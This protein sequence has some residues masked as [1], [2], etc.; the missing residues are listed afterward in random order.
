MV[1]YLSDAS[2]LA[3]LLRSVSE[4]WVGVPLWH[5]GKTSDLEPKASMETDTCFSYNKVLSHFTYMGSFCYLFP[6]CSAQFASEASGWKAKISSSP[7]VGLIA[8]W[9]K[10]NFFALRKFGLSIFGSLLPHFF[11]EN[12]S[13]AVV[14]YCDNSGL[15]KAHQNF[16]TLQA[17]ILAR[18]E[19][20]APSKGNFFLNQQRPRATPTESVRNQIA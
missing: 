11:K 13:S 14:T 8:P 18:Y 12:A 4:G 5:T 19:G 20:T 7:S 6:Q 1:Q 9:K 10:H 3:D 17:R 16:N 15:T 2:F